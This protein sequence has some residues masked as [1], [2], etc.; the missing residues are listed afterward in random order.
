M[1]LA[2]ERAALKGVRKDESKESVRESALVIL[3][4]VEMD[5]SSAQELEMRL[6]QEKELMSAQVS[7]GAMA[8]MMV[9]SLELKKVEDW[10]QE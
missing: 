10:G 6:A 1:T 5:S 3:R 7:E 2:L 9:S 4:A 8:A